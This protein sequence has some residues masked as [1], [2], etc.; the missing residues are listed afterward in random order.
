MVGRVSA[1]KPPSVDTSSP[2][3]TLASL[4]AF[5]TDVVKE[6]GSQLKTL[7]DVGPPPGNK[8]E[9]EWRKSIDELRGVQ[10]DVSKVV[11]DL[12]GTS[13]A[14]EEDVSAIIAKLGTQMKSLSSYGGP[15]AALFGNATIGPALK[16]EPACDKVS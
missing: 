14:N 6:Q 4:T 11:S 7:Q 15:V 16:S 5:F 9:K 8:A 1:I 3:A 2:E 13:A 10:D 12:K